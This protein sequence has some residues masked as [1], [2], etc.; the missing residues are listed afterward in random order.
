MPTKLLEYSYL[1]ITSKVTLL[2]Y[3][4]ERLL[5][6]NKKVITKDM[7]TDII[8]QVKNEKEL[9]FDEIAEAVGRHTVWTTSAIMGQATMSDKE[10]KKLINLLGLDPSIKDALQEIPYRGSLED[11]IPVDPLIYRFHEIT[12]VYGSTIKALIHEEFGD[13]IMSAIDFKM[14]ID[15]K[16]DPE[17][18]R[19]VITFDGKF[20]ET[21][22]W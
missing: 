7:A 17:G 1:K 20:L 8:L 18:D 9:T 19:V 14:D 13:G 16:E 10:A 4:K 2:Y 6:S 12:Q 15:R 22:K 21:K 5:L 3:K 11:E